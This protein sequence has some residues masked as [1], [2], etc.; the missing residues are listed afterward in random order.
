MSALPGFAGTRQLT[1]MA[2]TQAKP[3]STVSAVITA[4]TSGNAG[5]QIGF[6]H[7]EYSIDGG[8]TWIGICYD[9]NLGGE[10]SRS[11]AIKVGAEPSQTLVRAKAAFRGGAAGDVDF[12]GKPLQWEKSWSTW[13]VPPAQLAK[14]EV[15]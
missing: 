9:Q 7:A 13:S 15:K 3:G 6:L 12:Q 4:S 8:A 2:P 1:I 11:V 14:I 10:A 5:E